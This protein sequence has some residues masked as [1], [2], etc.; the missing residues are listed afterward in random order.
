MSEKL[1]ACPFCGKS[2]TFKSDRHPDL[3]FCKGDRCPG[4]VTPCTERQWN[5]RPI[6]DEL[7]AALEGVMALH[8]V[9]Q[10]CCHSEEFDCGICDAKDKAR[11]ALAKARGES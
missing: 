1:R 10:S 7:I 8:L 5:T 4:S 9:S 3:V 2:S 11:K 6:E